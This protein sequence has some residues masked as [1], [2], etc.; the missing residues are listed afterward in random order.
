MIHT[1]SF[2]ALGLMAAS[3]LL[4]CLKRDGLTREF[5]RN[6]LRF[7]L[8]AVALA[9]PQL[10]LWTFQSVGGNAS[11]LRFGFDWVN[12]GQENWFWFWLKNVGACVPDYPRGAHYRQE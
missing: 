5:L 3:W 9:V 1:H 11:F 7:G 4:Y 10:L 2:F 8:T 12:G 6:W